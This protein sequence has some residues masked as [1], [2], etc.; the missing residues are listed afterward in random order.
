MVLN[1]K[2]MVLCLWYTGQ[3]STTIAGSDTAWESFDQATASL[4]TNATRVV[5]NS[6]DLMKWEAQHL[7][8]LLGAYAKSGVTDPGVIANATYALSGKLPG[9]QWRS[10]VA[11]LMAHGE[12]RF[13]DTD[14]IRALD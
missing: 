4:F 14:F 10:V 12:L 9:A 2:S 7:S 3:V 8:T 11:A 6:H 5:T 1:P 13:H